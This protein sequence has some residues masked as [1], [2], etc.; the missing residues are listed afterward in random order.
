MTKS[1]ELN[2]STWERSNEIACPNLCIGKLHSVAYYIFWFVYTAISLFCYFILKKNFKNLT[3]W[4][5]IHFF[6]STIFNFK[7]N[8]SIKKRLG[9]KFAQKSYEIIKRILIINFYFSRKVLMIDFSIIHQK[10]PLLNWLIFS[11]QK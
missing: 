7:I 8:F 11:F 5:N 1:I 3:L 10:W 2:H 9:S 6:L 4:Q